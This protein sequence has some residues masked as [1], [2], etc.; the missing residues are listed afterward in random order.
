MNGRVDAVITSVTTAQGSID[1]G[2]PVKIVGD[3]VFNE[4]LAVGFD[5]S[6]DP[7]SES[8]WEAVDGIVADM[9]EDGTLSAMAEEW[10]GIDTTKQQ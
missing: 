9:H 1:E 5:K 2:S 3:P 6:S 8:L 4:P 10:Y 7:S